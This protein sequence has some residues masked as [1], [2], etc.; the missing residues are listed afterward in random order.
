MYMYTHI[1]NIYIYIYIIYI[2]IYIY[3]IANISSHVYVYVYNIHI[4]KLVF[5]KRAICIGKCNLEGKKVLEQISAA[6]QFLTSSLPVAYVKMSRLCVCYHVYINKTKNKHKTTNNNKQ[7]SFHNSGNLE[8]V[9]VLFQ[10]F[11]MTSDLC[12][13]RLLLMKNYF[14]VLATLQLRSI[15]K[16]VSRVICS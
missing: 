3:I 14:K 12:S 2:Y 9:F 16:L 13:G 4:Y 7:N 11:P 15:Q 5:T 10:L 1:Y 6:D 8:P